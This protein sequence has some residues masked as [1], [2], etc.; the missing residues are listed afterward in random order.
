MHLT[1]SLG[2]ES[3]PEGEQQFHT[4]AQ[5]STAQHSTAER[6]DQIFRRNKTAEVWRSAGLPCS[7]FFLWCAERAV[8]KVTKYI[9][10][11]DSS[12]LDLLASN[13]PTCNHFC[14]SLHPCIPL[15]S[16]A[17]SVASLLRC[18]SSCLLRSAPQI[19]VLFLKKS[20]SCDFDN[21][22]FQG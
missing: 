4:T 3:A 22:S 2:A 9:S 5:H 15:A 20:H 11:G 13:A 7:H 8:G 17:F 1:S 6:G 12:F 18:S 21:E 19:F 10:F 14:A 16:S